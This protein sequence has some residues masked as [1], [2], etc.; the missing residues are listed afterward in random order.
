MEHEELTRQGQEEEERRL[1]EKLLVRCRVG[2]AKARTVAARLLE[3]FGSLADVLHAQPDALEQVEG[4]NEEVARFV[5]LSA[6]LFE[7]CQQEEQDEAGRI[8]T[9]R[10]AMEYLRPYF[11][12]AQREQLYLLLL[13]RNNRVMTCRHLALGELD[14]VH[15]DFGAVTKLVLG[16]GAGRVILSHCHISTSAAPSEADE[17]NT[18]QLGRLLA[19]LNVKLVDH[20]IFADGAESSMA[21][22]GLLGGTAEQLYGTDSCCIG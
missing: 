11:F 9:P 1:L 4:V 16:S 7:R 22:L 8:K 17:Q 18:W 5:Q 6:A 21:E 13:D 12:S 3:D 19:E 10:D 2:K 14:S 15:L 20:I